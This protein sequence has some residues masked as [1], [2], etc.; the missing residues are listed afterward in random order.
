M[1][2]FS[3]VTNQQELGPN[4]VFH[5]STIKSIANRIYNGKMEVLSEC[6][7]IIEGDEESNFQFNDTY[8]KKDIGTNS[9][10]KLNYQCLLQK[11]LAM[12][13]FK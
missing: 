6:T 2:N 9:Y 12:T 13:L 8:I 10:R 7:L 3:Y 5:L 4:T 1:V 11:G